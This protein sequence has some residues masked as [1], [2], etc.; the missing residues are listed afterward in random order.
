MKYRA[1][2][3]RSIIELKIKMRHVESFI[4]V[5]VGFYSSN[6]FWRNSNGNLVIKLKE[7]SIDSSISLYLTTL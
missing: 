5:S 4:I 2:L 1:R 6:T 3:L 7:L